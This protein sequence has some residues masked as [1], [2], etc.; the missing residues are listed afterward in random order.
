ML[1]Q[2]HHGTRMRWSRTLGTRAK[3]QLVHK[4]PDSDSDSDSNDGDGGVHPKMTPM[5]TTKRP[6]LRQRLL[7]RLRSDYGGNISG[8]E[9]AATA[10]KCT[11]MSKART[12]DRA[13]EPEPGVRGFRAPRARTF[14]HPPSQNIPHPRPEYP[15]PPEPEHPRPPSS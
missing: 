10:D 2:N 5:A 11:M 6:R 15:A 13:H 9:G 4:T 1:D 3:C 12:V 14:P 8:Y 7:R